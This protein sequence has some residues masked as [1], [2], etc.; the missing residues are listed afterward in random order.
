MRVFHPKYKASLPSKARILVSCERK[1]GKKIERKYVQMKNYR[2][3]T[4]KYPV[5]EDG[6]CVVKEVSKWWIELR[7]HYSSSLFGFY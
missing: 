7:D 2:G 3:K 1:E 6:K 5:T 4:V